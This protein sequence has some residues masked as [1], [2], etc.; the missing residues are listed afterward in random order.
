M[1]EGS[2][3]LTC[4]CVCVCVCVYVG[5]GGDEGIEDP[6]TALNG[7]SSARQRNGPT[8]KAGLVAF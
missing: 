4:V 6:N 1:S 7:P 3:L 2:N 5:G 8:S